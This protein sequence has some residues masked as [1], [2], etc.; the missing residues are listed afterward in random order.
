[1]DFS[2][3]AFQYFYV[4]I[5]TIMRLINK[6]FSGLSGKAVFSCLCILLN[7][8]LVFG[9]DANKQVLF[10]RFHAT[11]DSLLQLGKVTQARNI[12][13]NIR[14]Q[15]ENMDNAHALSDA[16]TKLGRCYEAQGLYDSAAM[17]YYD[18]LNIAESSFD[19]LQSTKILIDLGVLYFNL[20]K[21][22]DALHFY[23]LALNK[24]KQNRDT[25]NQIRALNN[26]GNIYMTLNLDNEKAEPYFFKTVELATLTGYQAAVKV[27]L[28]NLT[29]IYTNTN[30]IDSAVVLAKKVLEFDREGHFGLYNLAN[31]FRMNRQPDSAIFYMKRILGNGYVEPELKQVVLKDIADVYEE[32]G[33]YK[34]AHDFLTEYLVHKDSI[35]KLESEKEILN[36][37]AKY[38]TAKKDLLISKLSIK[39]KVRNGI[40]LILIILTLSLLTVFIFINRNMLQKKVIAEHK[41]TIRTQQIEQLEK[42]KQLIAT[43]SALKGEE[44]ERTRMARDLHDGLGGLLS[45]IKLSLNNMKE[46]IFLDEKGQKMFAN[47]L[48]LLDSSVTELHNVANNMMPESLMRYGLKAAIEN[49]YSCIDKDDS[50]K[51]IFQFF[52]N[53]VRFDPDFEMTIYRTAQELLN[54]ALKHAGATEV[55][56]QLMIEEK[57]LNLSY[58]DNGKGFEPEVAFKTCGKGLSNIKARVQAFGGRCDIISSPGKGAE[59]LIEFNNI[60]KYTT[61]DTSN[62]C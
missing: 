13:L 2:G 60:T 57:R 4:I 23:Q 28:T 29:Q 53:D 50:C 3:L 41:L 18:A 14:N 43:T 45:G 36:L 16:I 56:L 30:R 25:L 52:G 61:D 40:I 27:G 12:F 51:I 32:K 31:I 24:A 59:V 44:N 33:N 49:Y 10:S 7:C 42:D 22:E 48:Q 34:D 58:Q 62:D 35:F 5:T 21:P 26:I 15:A 47:A 38:D 54:N 55:F 46:R 1:M 20:R 37:K 17:H 9:E 39:T 19:D 11:G 8:V 6:A